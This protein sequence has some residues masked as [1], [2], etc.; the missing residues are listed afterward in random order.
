[1]TTQSLHIAS[2]LVHVRAAHCAAVAAWLA[3]Q[4]DCEVRAQDP[5]GKLVVV[6][7]SEG[8]RP[9][10]ERID[11]VRC[12]TGVLDAALVYHQLLDPAIADEPQ[13]AAS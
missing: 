1:M 5:A 8:E 11:A 12:R 4:P 3:D 13:E 10:L 7:E 9:I 2:F 6:M